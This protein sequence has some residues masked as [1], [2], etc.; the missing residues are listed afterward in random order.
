MWLGE[1]EWVCGKVR[2]GGCVVGVCLGEEEKEELVCGWA[3]K[4]G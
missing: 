3:S 1:A 4:R 2:R